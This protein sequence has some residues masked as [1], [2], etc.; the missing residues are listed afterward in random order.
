MHDEKGEK[1]LCSNSSQTLKSTAF[2][3]DKVLIIGMTHDIMHTTGVNIF[4]Q[5]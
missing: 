2:L 4:Q 5:N 3:P 1:E